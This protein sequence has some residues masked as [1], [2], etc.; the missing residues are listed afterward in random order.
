[1]FQRRHYVTPD[2]KLLQIYFASNPGLTVGDLFDQIQTDFGEGFERHEIQNCPLDVPG[3]LAV[4]Q[5]RD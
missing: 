4:R 5:I 3:L 1:M 2:G